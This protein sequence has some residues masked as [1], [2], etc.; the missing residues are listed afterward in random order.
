MAHAATLKAL[1]DL[2]DT[3]LFECLATSVLREANPIY[4]PLVHTGVNTDGKT[5]KG[6]ID[7]VVFVKGSQQPHMISV[8]HTTGD[9]DKLE[10]KWLHDPSKV[11]RKKPG[12]KQ[13][14]PGDILK[15]I[16]VYT[17]ER[18]RTQGLIGTLVLT[19]TSDPSEELVRAAEAIAR[20]AGITIDLWP[21]S[22]IAHFLDT[23]PAGQWLRKKYLGIEQELLSHNLLKELSKKSLHEN[24]SIMFSGHESLWVSRDLDEEIDRSLRLPLSLIVGESGCGKSVACFRRLKEHIDGGGVGIV[25][26]HAV[27]AEAMTLD[28][29]IFL[30]LKKIHPSLDHQSLPTLTFSSPDCPMMVLIEDVNR[31]NRPQDLVEKVI[32]WAKN[33]NQNSDHHFQIL[34]PVWPRNTVLLDDERRKD[35]EGYFVLA[36][37]YSAQ[38]GE[39]AVLAKAK[40]SGIEISSLKAREI[41]EAL[42]YD[43]LLIAL[44]DVGET[45][46]PASVIGSY[47]RSALLKAELSDNSVNI[48]SEYRCALRDLAG[49]MLRHKQFE[50]TWSK[51]KSWNEID[52]ESVKAINFLARKGEV[53][54]YSSDPDGQIILF[55]HDRVRDWLLSDY[56]KDTV[57][58]G[59]LEQE[60]LFDP[61]YSDLIGR[62]LSELSIEENLLETIYQN[63]PLSLFYA[64]KFS[65]HLSEAKKQYLVEKIGKWISDKNNHTR[66]S[67]IIRWQALYV[68][69]ETDFSDIPVIVRKFPEN[70]RNSQLARLRNGDLSGGIELCANL[71][72][73]LGSPWR[74][75]QIAHAKDKYGKNLVGSLNKILNRDDISKAIRSGGLRLAGHIAD[76]LLAQGVLACWSTDEEREEH[77]DDYLWAF[78]RCWCEK[79]EEM[80]NPVM[81]V[82]AK[83]PGESHDHMPSPRDNLAAYN[84]RW[85]FRKWPPENAIDFFIR[86]AEREELR[87]PITYMLHGMDHPQ[88]IKFVVE[89]LAKIR[90]RLEGSNNF[91]PFVM[92]ATQDWER[93]LESGARKMSV[94]SLKVLL[95]LW[96]DESNDKHLR[97]QAFLIWAASKTPEDSHFLYE[98]VDLEE[99]RNCLIVERLK[100]GDHSA[101]P[102]LVEKVSHSNDSYWWQYGRYV[103]SEELTQALEDFLEERK[104]SVSLEYTNSL[105]ADWIISELMM[106]LP[107]RQAERILLKHWDHLRYSPQYVQVALY[108]ATTDCLQAANRAIEESPDAK[109]M[110]EHLNMHYGIKTTG[111]PGITKEKQIIALLPYLAQMSDSCIFSLWEACNE[112]GWF[113]LRSKHL[114]ERLTKDYSRHLWSK[115]QVIEQLDE[116]LAHDR[117]YW[118]DH[119][120]DDYI[121]RGV[122]WSEIF[123]ELMQWLDNNQSEEALNLIAD[124]VV[125]KG[126]RS[127]SLLLEKYIGISE[128]ASDVIFDTQ[129]GVK[130]RTLN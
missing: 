18:V 111:R 31:S 34:C 93:S 55:R 26:P 54:S 82:W 118:I 5:V 91:S 49:C 97:V 128:A 36:S 90:H 85:A 105:N 37:K 87:W 100:R 52:N 66:A 53:I 56:I 98:D 88:A 58:N 40:L 107:E 43:P 32:A 8:H 60:V 42:G 130:R 61:F 103:W 67:R 4:E 101:I 15:T 29:A 114:D 13:E 77:L 17:D 68:L 83:M 24:A 123:E 48:A 45:P 74:D 35:A 129:Y 121:N 57:V 11:K 65:S 47:I 112:R 39:N 80:L 72:P 106:A 89:E 16:A 20:S 110:L 23:D 19:V 79:S 51:L 63:N 12:A 1:A 70:N 96:K 127:D 28:Q 119:W 21:A 113:D 81:D 22:R 120:I 69:T 62:V 109:K 27:L 2:T 117:G 122:V 14:G 7:G 76:G 33:N 94:S 10:K 86:Y 44:Q 102:Y 3:G 71:E 108:H 84:L 104:G 73:G 25:I 41:A 95:N 126:S 64:L 38:E 92:N 125:Y 75:V 30:S 116:M 59:Q 124:A 6:P 9:R 78:A 99:L 50:V 46:D 115:R